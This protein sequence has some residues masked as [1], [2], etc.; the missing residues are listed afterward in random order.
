MD[1]SGPPNATGNK[2]R[3]P[4]MTR[5]VLLLPI[6]ALCA[7]GGYRTW[8]NHRLEAAR[9]QCVSADDQEDWQSV[10]KWGEIWT[11]LAPE[12]AEAWLLLADGYSK[13]GDFQRT[14]ECLGRIPRDD[15]RFLSARAM[16]GD[17]LLSEL[18]LASEAEQNWREML[19]VAP[20]AT[21]AHQRLIYLYSITLQ[22]G[23]MARQIRDAIAQKCEP[24]E[25][26]FYLMAR[27]AL[28]FSDGILRVGEWLK[29]DPENEVLIAANAVYRAKAPKGS[30]LRLFGVEETAGGDLSTVDLALK[31]VPGN[32]E[33]LAYHLEGLMIEGSVSEVADTLSKWTD[34]DNSPR[35]WRY[36]GWLLDAQGQLHEAIECYNRSLELDP[37]DWRSRH[38]LAGLQRIA[39]Q[40]A[41]STDNAQIAALGKSVQQRF[42]ELPN[43]KLADQQ[44]MLDL[45]EFMEGCGDPDISNALALRM[46]HFATN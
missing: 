6:V 29:K 32:P 42:F 2:E 43:A 21:L 26:Y 27:S 28:N 8:F 35:Y 5:V 18:H 44:L 3:K 4:W 41:E 39:G 33:L 38:E 34:T 14:A 11:R 20:N 37:F 10:V 30:A 15:E 1:D 40:S 23:K 19:E 46:S 17:L 7:W 25:A 45:L 9:S 13:Q 31:Q 22:R 36:R 12:D 24:R 16:R